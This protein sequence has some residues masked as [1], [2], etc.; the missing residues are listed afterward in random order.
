ME[1]RQPSN[2]KQQMLYTQ[3]D[4]NTMYQRKLFRAF[5]IL[6]LLGMLVSPF[7]I[8]GVSARP[9]VDDGVPP[10]PSA[11]EVPTQ[12]GGTGVTAEPLSKVDSELR[13]LAAEGGDQDVEVYILAQA[14]ADLSKVV[15]V[16]E[17]RP[18]R[19]ENWW[20]RRSNQT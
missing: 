19:M 7:Q 14:G 5:T 6:V 8:G 9:A 11:P 20:L 1:T 3:E 18:S 13:T 15:K 10:P 12:P 16:I 2:T 17:T 4:V